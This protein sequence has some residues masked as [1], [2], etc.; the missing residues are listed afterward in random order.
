MEKKREFHN[1]KWETEI[2][3]AQ[4]IYEKMLAK[5]HKYIIKQY[6]QVSQPSPV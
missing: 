5:E 4:G 3:E 1:E 6:Q 2:R